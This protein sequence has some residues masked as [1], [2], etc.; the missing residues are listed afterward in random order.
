MLKVIGINYYILI[1][2]YSLAYFVLVCMI[3]YQSIIHHKS[4]KSA[5][6]FTLSYARSFY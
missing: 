3:K 5:F 2:V 4:I 6:N 1:L